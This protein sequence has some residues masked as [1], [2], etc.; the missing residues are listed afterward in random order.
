MVRFDLYVGRILYL[1]THCADAA[2]KTFR[3]MIGRGQEVQI[4][5]VR[6]GE[7]A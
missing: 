2:F 1:S 6:I 4:K 7:A 3:S 5:F